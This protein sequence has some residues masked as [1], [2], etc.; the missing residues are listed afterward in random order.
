MLLLQSGF[1]GSDALEE[2]QLISATSALTNLQNLQTN[3]APYS[4]AAQQQVMGKL[5]QLTYLS[6]AGPD[7]FPQLNVLSS[8]PDLKTLVAPGYNVAAP[9]AHPGLEV[10]EAGRLVV[11]EQW[12]DKTAED[13]SIVDLTLS[14]WH[15]DDDAVSDAS[16]QNMPLLPQLTKLWC[17]AAPSDGRYLRLAAL[18]RRQGSKLRCITIRASEPFE[19]ALPQELPACTQ[20][21]LE[22]SAVSRHTLVALSMCSMPALQELQLSMSSAGL[23]GLNVAADLAWLRRLPQLQVLKLLGVAGEVAAAFKASVGV[24]LQ[25]SRIDVRYTT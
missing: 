12:R 18:L 22:S 21:S 23:A 24:L 1:K 2:Q 3:F 14:L 17:A 9:F 6:L 15:E 13:C 19:E 8:L 7:N 10:L 25:G 11:G 4:A 16:L 5:A 20:L